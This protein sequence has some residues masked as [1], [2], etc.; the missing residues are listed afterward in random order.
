MNTQDILVDKTETRQ[1]RSI[2]R[3]HAT[4]LLKNLFINFEP[5]LSNTS[6]RLH[7][8]NMQSLCNN[9]R[10]KGTGPDGKSN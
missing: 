4:L 5:L 3:A 10:S 7:I 9:N 1:P 6:Q 8:H 2:A